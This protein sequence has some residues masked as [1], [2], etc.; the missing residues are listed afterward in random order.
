MIAAIASIVS[1]IVVGSGVGY[2]IYK[3]YQRKIEE[4]ATNKAKPEDNSHST[5]AHIVDRSNPDAG[6]SPDPFGD[7][8]IF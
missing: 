4:M 5:R 6:G 2:V 8:D 7:D 3:R 1:L